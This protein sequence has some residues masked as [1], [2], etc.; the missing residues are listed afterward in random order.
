[1]VMR[2]EKHIFICTNQRAEGERQSCGEVHGLNLVKAFKKLIKDN[3]LNADVRAQRSSCL[4]ACEFGPSMVVYPEGIF[5][6]KV[7]LSDVEEIFNEHLV[8]N[9]PVTR[10]IIKFPVK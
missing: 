7:H 2:F 8:N 5:Y 10:L 4:D 1:M 3:G 6:G 9:R